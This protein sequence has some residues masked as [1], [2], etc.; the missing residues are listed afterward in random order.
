MEN[1]I[2][3]YN[4]TLIYPT[5]DEKTPWVLDIA[6]II[7]VFNPQNVNNKYGTWRLMYKDF[8]F[9]GD[10][11]SLDQLKKSFPKGKYPL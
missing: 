6:P 3:L 4:Q 5:G 7:E 2:E 8:R 11:Y 9:T 10:G 1:Y